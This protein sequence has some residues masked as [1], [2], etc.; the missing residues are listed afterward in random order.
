MDYLKEHMTKWNGNVIVHFSID[1]ETGFILLTNKHDLKKIQIR[2]YLSE[3]RGFTYKI[4][5]YV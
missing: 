4:Q 3:Y 1:C 5:I 2:K